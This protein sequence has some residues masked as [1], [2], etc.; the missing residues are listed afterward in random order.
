M[1]VLRKRGPHPGPEASGHHDCSES[2][3]HQRLNDGWGARIRTWD[4]GTKTRCLTTWPRPTAGTAVYPAR[5][6]E[7]EPS[8][9][10][11]EQR[12]EHDDEPC[13]DRHEHDDELR[14]GGGPG[15][16]AHVRAL[17]LPPPG[18]VARERDQREQHDDPPRDRSGEHEDALERHDREHDL[19]AVRAETARD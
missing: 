9:P 10:V 4:H 1:E 14:D 11:E 12:G 3:R 19:V 16:D 5:S 6:P 15:H 8:A 18:D 2:R 7:P 13:E 17:V